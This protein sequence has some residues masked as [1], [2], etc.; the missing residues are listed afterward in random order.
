MEGGREGERDSG[1]E[2]EREREREGTS[3]I[4]SPSIPPSAFEK[5]VH[6]CGQ[7][8]LCQLIHTAG[9]DEYFILPQSYTVGIHGYVMVYSVASM[10]R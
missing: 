4:V 3:V 8:F 2:R 1:R 7:E 6:Y 9:Q 10:K 5:V